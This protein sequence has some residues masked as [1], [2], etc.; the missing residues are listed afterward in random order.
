MTHIPTQ[1]PTP[2]SVPMAEAGVQV[3]G[4][5]GWVDLTALALLAVFFVL[6]LFRGFVWQVSRIVTLVLGCLVAARLGPGFA[7]RLAGWFQEARANPEL[8]LYIAY[9]A[10][11]LVVLLLVSFVAYFVQ[12]LVAK[13][14]LSFYDRLGGGVLGI[15]T[16]ALVVVVGLTLVLTLF[17]SMFGSGHQVVQAARRSQA[18]HLSQL[19]LRE[20]GDLVPAPIRTALQLEGAGATASRPDSRSGSQSHPQASPDSAPAARRPTGTRPRQDR[21]TR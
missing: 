1:D 21:G 12:K 14:G 6:G 5:L 8:A 4:N 11:F 18:L 16:G 13:I 3:L 17:A 19:T 2:A 15:G 7:G 20:L 10:I 9:F